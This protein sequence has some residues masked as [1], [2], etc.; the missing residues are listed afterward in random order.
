MEIHPYLRTKNLSQCVRE[1]N[2]RMEPT[3]PATRSLYLSMAV[4]FV[5]RK[6]YPI[7]TESQI[8]LSNPLTVILSSLRSDL[9]HPCG[10][11]KVYLI[12]LETVIMARAAWCARHPTKAEV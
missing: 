5:F 4:V 10:A 12:P 7:L 8:I 1:N 6:M 3:L 9:Y 2:A 11:T